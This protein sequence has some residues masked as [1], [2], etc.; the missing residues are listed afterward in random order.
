MSQTKTIF[1]NMSWLFVSQIIT[2]ICG[3][4]WIILMAR[5]L[6]V[7]RYGIFGFA[8]SITGILCILFDLGIELHSVRHIATDYVLNISTHNIHKNYPNFN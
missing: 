1:K 7:E 5:Y 6:G 3:F 4:I 8:V 2:S